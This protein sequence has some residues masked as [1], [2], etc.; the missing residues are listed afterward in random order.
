MG[1]GWRLGGR[2]IEQKRK[3]TCGHEKQCG[4]WWGEECIRGLNGNGKKYKKD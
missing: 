2:R 4:D 3:R 1:G